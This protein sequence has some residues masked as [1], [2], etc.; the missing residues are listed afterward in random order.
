[1]TTDSRK[2][3]YVFIVITLILSYAAGLA[4]W[5]LTRQQGGRLS[6]GFLMGYMFIPMI[7]AIVL[8]VFIYKEPLRTLGVTWKFNRWFVIGWLC[9]LFLSLASLGASSLVPGVHFSPSSA[10]MDPQPSP[11]P[12]PETGQAVDAMQHWPPWAILVFA[13]AFGL[14][15]GATVNAIA[16]FGEELGWRGFLYHHLESMGF[17]KSSYVIG[18]VW[19]VWHAPIILQGHNYPDYPVAGVF[20]MIAQ[21]VLLSPLFTYIRIR[22]QSVIAPAI[23]HGTIN[24]TYGASTLFIMGGTDLTTGA[25]GLPG[26]IILGMLNVAL[27]LLTRKR[28]KKHMVS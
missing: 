19:G 23:M 6:V 1:M 21:M 11:I 20:M 15:A 24:G 14:V 13:L 10:L 22:S 17:W 5:M 7:V 3:A 16:G 18:L 25:M 26:L 2:K 9:P 27:F 28:T 12:E 4:G 8:Q